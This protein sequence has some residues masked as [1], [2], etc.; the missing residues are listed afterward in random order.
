MMGVVEYTKSV[1]VVPHQVL[2]ADQEN[3][4]QYM[5]VMHDNRYILLE[6]HIEQFAVD[7][8]QVPYHIDRI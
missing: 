4:W 1:H 6:P 7:C 2:Q 5:S 3:E 8:E